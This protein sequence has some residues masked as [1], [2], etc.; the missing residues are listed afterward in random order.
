MSPEEQK[1]FLDSL[2]EEKRAKFTTGSS[3]G[4]TGT[5]TGQPTDAAAPSPG[6]ATP[7]PTGQ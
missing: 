3:Q 2:P 4:E 6:S 5:T 1:A 7:P